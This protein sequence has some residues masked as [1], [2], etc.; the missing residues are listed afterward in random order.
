MDCNNH[1]SNSIRISRQVDGR[2]DRE[3][4]I[5][6]PF[7]SSDLPGAKNASAHAT[8]RLNSCACLKETSLDDG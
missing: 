7:S 8:Q 5:F 4:G 6:N 3:V 2:Q 1:R